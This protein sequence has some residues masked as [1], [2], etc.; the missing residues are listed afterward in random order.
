MRIDSI[1]LFPTMIYKFHID[2]NLYNKQSII[3]IVEKNYQKNSYRNK[4]DSN[5]DI[6]HSYADFDNDDYDK[7]VLDKLTDVYNNTFTELIKK[8]Q[9]KS[10][11]YSLDN[12]VATKGSQYMAPHNHL[13]VADYSCI[14]YIKFN[15]DVHKPTTFRNPSMFAKSLHHI[16]PKFKPR[17]NEVD[18]SIFSEK[19]F[20]LTAEDDMIIIPSYLEHQVDKS[21]ND[22]MRITIVTN[23][24]VND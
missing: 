14:H 16:K 2:P 3:D 17:I 12:I 11:E 7:P 18:F 21:Y 5:S 6:H 1:P 22:E 15:K 20:V 24:I 4:F 8:L 19:H 9:F 23:L 13:P 10:F